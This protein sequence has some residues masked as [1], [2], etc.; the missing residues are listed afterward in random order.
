MLGG[1]SRST[2]DY[3]RTDSMIILSINK[4]DKKAKMTSIMRDTWVSYPGRASKGKINAANVYGGPELAMETVNACFGTDIKDYVMVNMAGLVDVIDA[5]GGVNIDVTESERKLT[6]SYAASLL[7]T[8]KSYSGAKSL[9]KSGSNVHLNG[10]LA[11]TYC[12]DRYSDSD[13]GR[14]QRKRKVLLAVLDEL[15]ESSSAE[16]ALVVT[17]T[18]QNVKTNLSLIDILTL[19]SEGMQIDADSI[20]QYRIPADN[21]FNSGMQN[22]VWSI[23][24]DFDKNEELLR[25]FIYGEDQ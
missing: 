25:E 13:Y 8:I 1:D 23:R 11:V 22:G 14:T 12:R 2:S 20:E 19:A 16:L 21:T 5:V 9:K 17:T 15:R 24:P 10:L 18:F 4:A 7:K 6:N 3:G